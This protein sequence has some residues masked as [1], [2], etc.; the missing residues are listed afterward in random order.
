MTQLG[1]QEISKAANVLRKGGLVAIPT[2]TVYGL[3]ADATNDK[4]V[5]RIFDAKERPTFNPLIAHVADLE[6]AKTLADF[7]PIAVKLAASFWPGPLTL[8]LPRRKDCSISLLANAGLATIAL[9]SPNHPVA[10][11]LIKTVD[12]PLAAPSANS[13]GSIS[14]T[15]AEHVRQG[16]GDKVDFILDGGPSEVG[17]ESTIIKITDGEITVLRPGGITRQH[18]EKYVGHALTKT[19]PSTSKPPVLE[20]PGML[21]NHYAPTVSMRLNVTNPRHDEAYLG[22]GNDVQHQHSLNLS[23]SSDL[24]EAASNLF[25]MMHE[26]DDYCHRHHLSVISV[27]PIPNVGLG[28]AINDRLTRAAAPR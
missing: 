11:A 27:A 22:F 21:T 16:L 1:W 13:S 12:H 5:A 25:A 24:I 3:A 15:T 6:M 2:E 17:V 28:E 10:Q 14:P 9:R 26:L 19:N 8:I 7:C 4:A 20:A 23:P 18:L